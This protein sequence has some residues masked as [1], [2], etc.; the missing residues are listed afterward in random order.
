M[1][2]TLFG[3][4]EYFRGWSP[5]AA[6][7][8]CLALFATIPNPNVLNAYHDF[9]LTQLGTS[10]RYTHQ[11][12]SPLSPPYWD[13]DMDEKMSSAESAGDANHGRLREDDIESLVRKPLAL[14]SRWGS[15]S[16]HGLPYLISRPPPAPPLTP[17]ELSST[18]FTLD[19]RA[20]GQDS[21]IHQPNPDY[22]SASTPSSGSQPSTV[23][24]TSYPRRLSYNKTVPIGIPVSRESS[25]HSETDLVFPANSYPP[26]SPVL[27]PPPTFPELLTND[28]ADEAKIGL[29]GELV[30]VLDQDGSGWTRHTRVYGGGVCLACA[31]AG[32]EHGE[33]GY[34][35]DTVSPEERR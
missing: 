31:A 23:V 30:A 17:P 26:T 11:P 33:G 7:E 24:T 13:T 12:P 8:A 28:P 14:D 20:Q 3:A 5:A 2:T 1:V 10:L 34:Y 25:S 15:S 6:L 21:F 29:Q 16:A 35:G 22:T 18:V 19:V 32:R 9:D 4:G 27:P